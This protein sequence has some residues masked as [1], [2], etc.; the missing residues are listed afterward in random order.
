MPGA[1]RMD[2]SNAAGWNAPVDP[3][4]AARC[5][6]LAMA[7]GHLG[8]ACPAL[9][10]HDLDRMR[11]RIA[12]LQAVFP[13]NTLHALA[14]KA[15]PLEG[16]L[17]EAVAAGAGLEAASQEEVWL[18][19]A[20][21]CP[22][23]RIVFDSPAKTR[24]E[25]RAAVA[26]GVCM[27]ADNEHELARLDE[28][29]A[30]S[31]RG[32]HR[33]GL[34][35]NPLVGAGA[36][37]ITSVGERGS[38]F[39]I[40]TDDFGKVLTLYRRFPW[41]NGIHVHVGS[42]GS[43]LEHLVEAV[44]VAFDCVAR[45]ESDTGRSMAFIDIGGGLP[46]RYE[47]AKEPPTPEDYVQALRERVPALSRYDG[48]LIT[49]FGRAIQASCGWAVSR[50]EYVKE[51]GGRRIAVLHLGADFLMRTVYQP[52]NWPHRFLVLTASGE[53]KES[54]AEPIDFAGPLCF[55]GDIVGTGLLLPRVEEGDL[56]VVCETG[57]YTLSLWSRHCNRAVPTVLG[58]RGGPSPSLEVLKP[59]E[60]ERDVRSLWSRP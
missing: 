54:V 6:R 39:G 40:A 31:P 21:G 49:E 52:A 50:V 10:F 25:L 27:N 18:A 24:L 8:E 2:P 57:A 29:L 5:V 59:R 37:G 55:A 17:S 33:V 48:A 28:I 7:A 22:P 47:L 15:N 3:R 14:I 42:Q 51:S 38:K 1:S 41:L 56:V 16:V 23:G 4:H 34:R 13:A 9:L 45:I 43:P 53:L 46:A 20:A 58:V 19:Q 26:A 35:V 30:G 60:E 12:R 11:E 36:I 32:P 44:R